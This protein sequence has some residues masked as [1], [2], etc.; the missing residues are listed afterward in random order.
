[1]FQSDRTRSGFS[2]PTL[3]SASAPS[4]ASTISWS[5]K[6]A[7]RRVR[8]TI[9]R[10]TRLSSAIRIFTA[11]PRSSGS[12]CGSVGG[13]RGERALHGDGDGLAA[14]QQVDA[15]DV[16]GVAGGGCVPHVGQAQAGGAG[17]RGLDVAADD[18]GDLAERIDDVL[19]L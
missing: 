10:M 17:Q 4:S 5:S 18:V 7:W 11:V 12:R 13:E 16:P 6:P 15:A 19:V 9:C 3:A 2:D 1:M 8:M 14:P